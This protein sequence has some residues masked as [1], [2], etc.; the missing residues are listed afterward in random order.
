MSD[1]PALV[2][3]AAVDEATEPVVM[4][5]IWPMYRALVGVG[6]LCGFL[7]VTVFVLTGPII[8]KN[9]AEAL[10][11]AIFR[12]LPAATSSA[13]FD[14]QDDGTFVLATEGPS[15][16][17]R[18]HA[19]FDDGGGLVGLAIEA[20][21]MGYQ[22]VVKVLYGYEPE[23]QTIV[24]MEVLESRETP[25]LGTRIETDEAFLENFVAL[26][27][28]LNAEGTEPLHVIESVK[29]GKRTDP[30]QIDTISGAT[31]SSVAVT[32]IL[33]ASSALWGPR[34]QPHKGDFVKG[35]AP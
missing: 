8:A 21:G 26:D 22:D 30:W 7:I 28:Q 1:E 3:E 20:Q 14:L 6:L 5:P 18:L 19:G 34:I 35:G 2:D 12:L 13:S 17:E 23:A 4:P 29:P 32:D 15:A 24:G 31:I 27:V 25:G 33:R 9:R 10:Q 16:T 11:A